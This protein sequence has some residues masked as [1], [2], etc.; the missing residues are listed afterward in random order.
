MKPAYPVS[1]W[2]RD[3][4]QA[5]LSPEELQRVESFIHT[6]TWA[7]PS[8]RRR[9]WMNTDSEIPLRFELKIDIKG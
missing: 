3:L 9:G 8:A 7:S 4:L 6:E 1:G 5:H 2:I